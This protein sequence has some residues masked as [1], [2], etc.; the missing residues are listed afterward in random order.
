MKS[1][2]VDPMNAT[3]LSKAFLSNFPDKLIS[4]LEVF[5]N[6]RLMNCSFIYPSGSRRAAFDRRACEHA[7]DMPRKLSLF[8]VGLLMKINYVEIYIGY[9]LWK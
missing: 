4:I 9:V 6:I 8:L 5:C 7:I 2:W 3:I 1:L